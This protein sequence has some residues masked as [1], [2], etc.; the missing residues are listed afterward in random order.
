M[1][2]NKAM[3]LYFNGKFLIFYIE[4][5]VN[6]RDLIGVLQRICNN[7]INEIMVKLR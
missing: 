7:V 5:I 1:N 2:D 6:K 3:K 4:D